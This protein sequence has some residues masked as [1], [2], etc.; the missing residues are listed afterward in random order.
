M[1]AQSANALSFGNVIKRRRRQLEQTQAQIAEKVGCRPNYIGYLEVG[2]RHPS[3]KVVTKLAKALDLDE[4]EMFLLANPGLRSMVAPQSAPEGSAWERFKAN[5]RMH[6]RHGI[7]RAELSVLEAV[8]K[9]G[10]MCEQRD[11]L[12]ILQAIRQGM[13]H[14]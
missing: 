14:E 12:F 8:S 11:F 6:T 5:K 13:T 7:T 1:G 9:I 3:P 10:P 4:Q 2:A